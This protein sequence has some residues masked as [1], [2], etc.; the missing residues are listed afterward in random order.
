MTSSELAAAVPRRPGRPRSET[1]ERGEVAQRLLDAA[2]E[3]AVEQGFDACGLREIAARADVSSGM[4]AYYFGDR[5]GLYEAMF[6]RAIDRV[7]NQV[8]I[9]LAD[10]Q[11]HTHD[12]LDELVRIHIEA[13]AA[14]PWLPK[15]IISEMLARND[16][17]IKNK[18]AD[19]IGQGPMQ[20][21]IRWIEEEQARG[22]LRANLDARLLAM[23][24]ASLAVFPFL[25]LPIVGDKIGISLDDEFPARLIEHNQ[26]LLAHGIRARSEN[27]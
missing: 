3:L 11:R 9:L 27:P 26:R 15:L 17:S 10:E 13:V 24:I 20:L 1:G 16:S 14:D 7:S 12:R 21:M 18:I 19:H 4:I 5:Q 8:T 25:M 6:Q 23:T 22:I 2:T